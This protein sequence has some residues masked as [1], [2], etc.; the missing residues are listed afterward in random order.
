MT[1]LSQVALSDQEM[2]LLS[3][4]FTRQPHVIV[5]YLFG[6]YARGQ[7]TPLSDMDTTPIVARLRVIAN[8]VNALR[9]LGELPLDE[10]VSSYFLHAAA[11]RS[12][13]AALD[14]GDRYPK[15]DNGRSRRSL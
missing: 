8:C 9:E 14:I 15:I 10:F 5:A 6:S 7:A 11:E 12:F 3:E 4:Y 13:Q 2:T 1:P